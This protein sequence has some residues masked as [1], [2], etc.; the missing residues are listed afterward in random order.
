MPTGERFNL[1]ILRIL[2]EDYCDYAL[3]EKANLFSI[4]LKRKDL[5]I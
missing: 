2:Q 4:K 1:T 3:S 5:I